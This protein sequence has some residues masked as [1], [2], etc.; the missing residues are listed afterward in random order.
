M[1]DIIKLP[2][3]PGEGTPVYCGTLYPT[4]WVEP[5]DMQEEDWINQGATF[6]VLESALPWVIGD[7]LNAG[8]RKYGEKYTQAI[9]VTGKKLEQLKQWCWLANTFALNE[10]YPLGSGISYTHHR[11]VAKLP[12]EERNAWLATAYANG[13][14]SDQLKAEI[15]K[16]NG[17]GVTVTPGRLTKYATP[18]QALSWLTTNFDTD[19]LAVFAELLTEETS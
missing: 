8:Q 6:Q 10:R 14:N 5:E 18:E 12:R 17:N 4:G 19:W 2:T 13:W 16:A 7:W 3:D 15:E 11:T 1:T 9:L